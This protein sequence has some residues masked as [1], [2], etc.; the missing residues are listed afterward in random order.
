MCFST[1]LSH[2]YLMFVNNIIQHKKNRFILISK[3]KYSCLNTYMCRKPLLSLCITYHVLHEEKVWK[4]QSEAGNR[5]RA[6][7]AM[8][9]WKR[10]NKNLQW[11]ATRISLFACLSKGKGEWLWCYSSAIPWPPALLVGETGI[12]RENHRHTETRWQTLSHY[13]VSITPCHE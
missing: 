6:E 9:K 8:A 11:N 13:V 3:E 7:N 10:T 12:P 1:L 2:F 4:R 5:R